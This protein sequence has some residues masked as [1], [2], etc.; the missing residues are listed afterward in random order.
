V[1]TQLLV[2][3]RLRVSEII[4]VPPPCESM[5]CTGTLSLPLPVPVTL[6]YRSH[7]FTYQVGWERGEIFGHISFPN[8][9]FFNILNCDSRALLLKVLYSPHF[10]SK[11]TINDARR[12]DSD[13]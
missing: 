3:P 6:L 12:F 5:T 4:H 10:D 13:N 8:S 1:T 7:S 9:F 11:L 2:V